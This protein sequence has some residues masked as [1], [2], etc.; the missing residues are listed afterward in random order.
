MKFSGNVKCVD[1]LLVYG[2]Y[3]FQGLF[4]FFQIISLENH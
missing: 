4:V 1:K 2:F 3:C